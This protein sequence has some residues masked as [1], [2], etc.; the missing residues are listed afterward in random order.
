MIVGSWPGP[1]SAQNT[2]VAILCDAL[3]GAGCEVVDVADVTTVDAREI[4]V[5]HIHWPEEVF[6][7][8]GRAKQ[9]ARIVAV[10]GALRRLHRAGVR[11]V[12]MVHNLAPHESDRSR[13]VLWA[14]LVRG[15]R[16]YVDAY[17]TLSVATE[18][19]V[20]ATLRPPKRARLTSV[21][22]PA[23]P[24][25]PAVADARERLGIPADAHVYVFF[26][27]IRPYKGIDELL[28]AFATLE[29]ARAR[30]LI[31]GKPQSDELRARLETAARRDA[32]I[33]VRLGYL[34]EPTL[35]DVIAT[36]DRVVLPLVDYLH[37]GSLIRALSQARVV[38]TPA[39]PFATNLR[40][41]VGAAYVR[42]YERPLRASQLQLDPV[43]LTTLPSL[44]AF[45]PD[46]VARR[47]VDVYAALVA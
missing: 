7:R 8:G 40:D 10:L 1:R 31:A 12:W 29:D 23:Y 32:R 19:I 27:L 15:L 28:A 35:S 17:V 33:D 25:G 41:E 11:I 34:D 37:S 2:F 46:A 21:H 6:W 16:V 47:L 3:A 24:A 30:L 45:A 20:A 42:L 22:H 14:L 44:A 13:R 9:L 18:P 36:A 43:P 5:L 4:D 39:T 38:V 26:G